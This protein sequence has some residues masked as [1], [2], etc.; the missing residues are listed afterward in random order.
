VQVFGCIDSGGLL[1]VKSVIVD[2][3]GEIPGASAAALLQRSPGCLVMD[4]EPVAH[5]LVRQALRL[6]L[7]CDDPAV[8]D[9]VISRLRIPGAEVY[10]S[11]L[12]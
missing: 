12:N 3:V 5:A 11:A 8:V 7:H 1:R 4:G 2:P 9:S 10:R 6:V